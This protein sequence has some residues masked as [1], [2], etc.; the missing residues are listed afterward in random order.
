MFNHFHKFQQIFFLAKYLIITGN[1]IGL[2]LWDLMPLS[3]LFQLYRG[4]QFYWWRK[5]MTCRK[6]SLGS[7]KS[8]DHTTTMARNSLRGYTFSSSSEYFVQILYG[9]LMILGYRVKPYHINVLGQQCC[10]GN[11]SK[12]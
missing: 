4:C 10:S 7:C 8:K 6:S 1:F 5:P 2:G 3:T 12:L 9:S 11:H